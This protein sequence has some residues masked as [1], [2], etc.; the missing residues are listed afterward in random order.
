MVRRPQAKTKEKMANQ[1]EQAEKKG[2]ARISER[3]A[4]F[5][6]MLLC[7]AGAWACVRDGAARLLADKALSASNLS[8]ADRSVAWNG[9]DAEA[10]Y[11][12]AV[13]LS[14]LGRVDQSSA[15]FEQAARLRPR[16]YFLWLELGRALDEKGD[17]QGARAA[18]A[19]AIRLAPFY[20]QPR[21][22]MGNLLF[23]EGE[24]DAAFAE[25]RLASSSDPKL[26]P[27]MADLA[28]AAA[29][30]D[31]ARVA[32][33]SRP[34]TKIERLQLAHLLA[35]NGAMEEAQKVVRPILDE[36]TSIESAPL[37]E[38]LIAR[39]AYTAAREIW[40]A[41]RAG[42]KEVEGDVYDG[43]FETSFVGDETGFGWRAPRRADGLKLGLDLNAPFSGALSLLLEFTG[44]SIPTAQIVSQLVN[45][46]PQTRY[47]LRFAAR[48]E[49]LRMGGEPT[50]HIAATDANQ[51]SL[52]K[53]ILKQTD[54][55]LWK[56]YAVEF[57][58][59][60]TRAVLIFVQRES[61]KS[62]PCPAFGRLWIDGFRLEKN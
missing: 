37:V 24:I 19:E 45:V 42:A 15:E 4:A 55:E 30:G 62:G 25:L 10:R 58:T 5:A 38:E 12:R 14:D 41:G 9:A 8:S 51:T 59:G 22:Q 60:E 33:L 26:F 57:K 40:A 35:K 2:R 6:C 32:E 46:A 52:A 13:V 43:D 50:L 56:E 7:C 34:H 1:D 53:T 17:S 28:F 54:A 16:D 11:A 18:F 20:A 23:R 27:V 21:W 3:L 47:R 31:D 29:E 61:C 49:K 44:E 36:T 39:G 48:T